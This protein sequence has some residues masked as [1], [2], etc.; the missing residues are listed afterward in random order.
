VLVKRILL[1]ILVLLEGSILLKAGM[2]CERIEQYGAMSQEL[3]E[4]FQCGKDFGFSMFRNAKCKELC[5]THKTADRRQD[6]IKSKLLMYK[7]GY[8]KNSK[9]KKRQFTG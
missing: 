4:R 6:I 8:M 5:S 7:M 9:R 2:C 1:R 3:R